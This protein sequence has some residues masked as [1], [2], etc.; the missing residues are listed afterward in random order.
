M[1]LIVFLE[2]LFLDNYEMLRDLWRSL[3]L[4]GYF[5][6]F[7]TLLTTNMCNIKKGSPLLSH[8]QARGRVTPLGGLLFALTHYQALLK[9][10]T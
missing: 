8:L 7:I 6:V 2:L 4:P 10:I 1:F 9:T 3:S 5:M